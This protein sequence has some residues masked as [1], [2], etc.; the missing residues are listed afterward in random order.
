MLVNFVVNRDPNAINGTLRCARQMRQNYPEG[1]WR[2]KISEVDTYTAEYAGYTVPYVMFHF[3]LKSLEFGFERGLDLDFPLSPFE[4]SRY[5]QFMQ[6]ALDALDVSTIDYEALKG[7]EGVLKLGYWNVGHYDNVA[8][9]EFLSMKISKERY[10]ERV[11]HWKNESD[12]EDGDLSCFAFDAVA[13]MRDIDV[14]CWLEK[15]EV[16]SDE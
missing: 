5:A 7:A 10:A 12:T 2:Y 4:D 9:K 1:F 13:E 15:E 8:V 6:L 11:E 3:K 14:N 16:A